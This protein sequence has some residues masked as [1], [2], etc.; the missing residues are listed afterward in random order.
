M[1]PIFGIL[2]LNGIME[3]NQIAN[4]DYFIFLSFVND[5]KKSLPN[6]LNG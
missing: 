4:F 2:K 5:I 6:M 1:Q 3:I